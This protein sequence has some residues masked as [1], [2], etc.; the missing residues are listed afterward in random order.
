MTLQLFFPG[1][2]SRRRAHTVE[3]CVE[4]SQGLWGPGCVT[5]TNSTARSSWQQFLFVPSVSLP[6]LH[7]TASKNSWNIRKKASQRWKMKVFKAGSSE[8]KLNFTSCSAFTE[9]G[10]GWNVSHFLLL[11]LVHL[12]CNLCTTWLAL[13]QR[14]LHF[15]GPLVAKWWNSPVIK[16][17]LSS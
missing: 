17:L 3:Q 1:G 14:A 6:S 2:G 15:S 8:W 11:T 12:K 7:C 9:Q 4:T 10:W 16:L 13:F 5:P